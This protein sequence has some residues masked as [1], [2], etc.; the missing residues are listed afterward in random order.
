MNFPSFLFRYL[1]SRLTLD[2]FAEPAKFPDVDA[3]SDTSFEM[4]KERVDSIRADL[5]PYMLRRT[6]DQVLNLPPLVCL[7]SPFRSRSELI[8]SSLSR[9]GRIRC[10]RQSHNVTTSTLSR[11]PRE[12]FGCY[13]F[14]RQ[15][16]RQDEGE[17]KDYR[18][19]VSFHF[20]S[21]LSLTQKTDGS[22][23]CR[24]NTLMTLRK[25]V[26]HPYLHVPELDPGDSV[27]REESF[28]QLT[29]ASAK[30][31]LLERM[32]PKLREK[33]HK[34]LIFSQFKIVLN[35]LG[36][37]LDGIGT[38]WLRLDGDTPQLDRQRGVSDLSS[39]SVP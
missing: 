37:F 15:Q 17:S 25:I 27:S 26:C 13:P 12:E 32:L 29:D 6:K 21:F 33:G 38:K 36:P 28:R 11:Y 8:S 39:T 18:D 2:P 5:A 20:S 24:S 10:S 1:Y 3:L 31:L 23:P 35:K 14:Y 30:L 7:L 19:E 9:K 16:C 22:F 34:V 4:T